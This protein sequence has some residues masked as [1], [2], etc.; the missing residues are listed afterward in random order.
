[1]KQVC[2]AE[3]SWVY[4]PFKAGDPVNW[5]SQTNDTYS[6]YFPGGSPFDPPYDGMND[7]PVP[8]AGDPPT[9]AKISNNA[10]NGCTVAAVGN[11]YFPYSIVTPGG[12]NT[13]MS[14]GPHH[15]YTPGLHV[16]P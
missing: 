15:I 4:H 9:A 5:I 8:K 3:P 1:M 13:C 12:H 11:C 2:F 6:V 7:I 14:N 16:K 10:A